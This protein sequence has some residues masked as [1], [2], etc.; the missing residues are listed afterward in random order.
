MPRTRLILTQKGG[1]FELSVK[2]RVSSAGKP[3]EYWDADT[4][5]KV[6]SPR[7]SGPQA[8]AWATAVILDGGRLPPD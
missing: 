1:P 5:C 6:T 4:A 8:S 3:M 7:C 2:C